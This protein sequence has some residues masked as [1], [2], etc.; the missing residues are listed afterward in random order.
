MARKEIV[1]LPQMQDYLTVM[2]EQIQK[3]RLRRRLSLALAA[4]RADISVST[5][6]RVEKGDKNVSIG[7]YA[8]VLH[9]IAGMDKDLLLIAKD[10]KMEQARKEL[11][12]S[13]W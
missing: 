9:A 7:I 4:E 13:P 1:L 11:N 5:L 6:R 8:Q 12:L 2:G 3:A 10:E